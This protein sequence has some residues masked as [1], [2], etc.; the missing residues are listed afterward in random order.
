MMPVETAAATQRGDALR[1][2]DAMLRS[3]PKTFL[4][5]SYVKRI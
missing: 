2:G 4:I 3:I 5:A 1:M